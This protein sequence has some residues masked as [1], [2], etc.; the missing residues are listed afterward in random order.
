MHL[1]QHINYVIV[2]RHRQPIS[3]AG[4]LSPSLAEV[5]ASATV[6]RPEAGEGVLAEGG[7]EDWVDVA[8]PVLPL[9]ALGPYE[10]ALPL[11]LH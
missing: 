11:A 4:R 5:A 6:A 9:I 7:A 2:S 10:D 8:C 1:P 3:S